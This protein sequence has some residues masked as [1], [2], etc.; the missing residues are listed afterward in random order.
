MV[1]AAEPYW[2]ESAVTSSGRG[3]DR[4]SFLS[5]TIA[6]AA[7]AACSGSDDAGS[8]QG[9]ATTSTTSTTAADLPVPELPADPFT[10]GVASGDPLPASVILWTRLAPEPSSGGGMPAE[11]VP[12]RWEVATDESF[13][14]VV[15]EGTAVATPS[16]GHSVHVDADGLEPD[17]WYHYRFTVGDW[18]S[19]AGRTRTAP[20]P[21]ATPERF[22]FAHASCQNYPAGYYHAHAQIARDELD[23]VV[24]LGDYIY[25]G[26][27]GGEMPRA[28]DSG[29]VTDLVGYRNRY[30]LY[31]GDPDLQAAHAACPWVITWDDHEV[32]NNY[33]GDVPEENSLLEGEEFLA[34]R[35]AGYQAFYEHLPIRVDPPDGPDMRIYRSMQW[36]TLAELFVLDGRQY[37]SDQPCD[38][39]TLDLGPACDEWSEPGRTM[40]GDDQEDWLLDGLGSSNRTWKVIANQ[41][42]MSNLLVGAAVLNHDQWDGYPESRRRLVDRISGADGGSAVDNTVV[43]TGDIHIAGVGK[44]FAEDDPAQGQV[45]ATE[46]VCT[47]ISSVAPAGIPADTVAGLLESVDYFNA[48][49]RGYTRNEVT[50]SGWTAD[51]VV[52]DAL[53]PDDRSAAVDATFEIIPG[54]PG[55]RR[56]G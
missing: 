34:R 43:L 44:L 29:E 22:R 19:P 13:G 3:F 16:F 30:A 27:G 46:L 14:D 38:D 41:T 4:R 8:A 6:A 37:R 32:D 52:V 36:G 55:A 51:F 49:R 20:E 11:D 48:D 15:S 23:L 24:F 5:A 10:L 17:S 42:V 40:L 56:A 50:P 1:A 18:T 21:D 35:A 53:D 7:A 39:V 33:A 45:I 9:S 54:Q 12:V 28:H 31:K 47:S 25:E 26:P 2:Y